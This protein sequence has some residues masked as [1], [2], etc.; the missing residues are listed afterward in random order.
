MKKRYKAPFSI[1]TAVVMVL[2]LVLG[3][4]W[5]Q[6]RA[7]AGAIQNSYLHLSRMKVDIAT[8]V[9]MVLAVNPASSFT[10]PTIDIVFPDADDGNWCRTNGA[11]TVAG[12][13]TGVPDQ[14]GQAIDSALPGTLSAS[15]TAGSG[16]GSYDTI[17]ITGVTALTN[18]T[19]Y[20]VSLSG[21]V[22]VLGTDD[23]TGNHLTTINIT[24][25]LT[26]DTI[27][28]AV[29][30][31]TDDQVV[32]TASVVEAP[33]VTCSL[34]T[35]SVALGTLYQGGSYSTATHTITASTSTGADGYYWVAYGEGDG[36]TDAGLYKSVATADLLASTGSGTVDLTAGEGFGM[37]VTDPD[38]GSSTSE[39]VVADFSDATT[40]TFGALDRAFAGAQMIMYQQGAAETT[41]DT[42][43]VTYGARAG[44]AAEIGSYQETVTFVCGG[45]Y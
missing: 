1:L 34:S 19:T 42:A 16:A 37:V 41:G 45:Y 12:T 11:L 15:C 29:E 32:I 35:N 28:Y 4:V 7:E 22:G 9:E 8:G 26:K 38:S 40:G 27:T 33:T 13:A 23:T 30:L 17:T 6:N 39:A 24:E 43:T 36:T 5:M 20:G 21:S 14:G 31:V 25:G 3:P 10:T 18:G 44:A 2:S